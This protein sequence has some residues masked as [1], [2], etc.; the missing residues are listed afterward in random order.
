MVP[1]ILV[2]AFIAL[3]LMALWGDFGPRRADNGVVAE[4]VPGESRQR[5]FVLV[6]GFN[7]KPLRWDR[8]SG[9]LKAHGDV[10]RLSY[11]ARPVANGD[12]HK[13]AQAIGDAVAEHAAGKEVVIVA[14]S[15]GALLARRAVLDGLEQIVALD[16]KMRRSM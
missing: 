6:H 9:A 3:L 11:D 1:I 12:P 15:M 13:I 16:S 10:L 14:H 2:A 7:P 5:V 4:H 8:L